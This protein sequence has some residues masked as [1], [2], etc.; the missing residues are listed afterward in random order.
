MANK[1]IYQ[2]IT[3]QIISDLEKGLPVWEKPWKTGFPGFPKNVFTKSFYS[4][5][6]TLILW[7][8]QFDM[9]LDCTQWIT[10]RQAQMLGGHVKKGERA[11]RIIFYKTIT[12]E[13]EKKKRKRERKKN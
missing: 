8:R 6:N 11:S 1:D 4:G 2:E 12:W 13:E 10:F 5:V 7:S 9:G 3:N